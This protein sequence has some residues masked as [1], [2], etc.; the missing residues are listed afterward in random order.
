M[1]L[2]QEGRGDS[3]IWFWK[4]RTPAQSVDKMAEYET[5]IQEPG[6][7]WYEAIPLNLLKCWC[8][9]ESMFFFLMKTFFCENMCLPKK[10]FFGENMFFVEKMVF[11]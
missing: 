6:Q 4:S 2:L 1:H 11:G 10:C 5:Q 8:S 3:S 9:C 7:T